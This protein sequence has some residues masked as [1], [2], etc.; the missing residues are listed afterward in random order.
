MISFACSDLA[1]FGLPLVTEESPEFARLL[2]ELQRMP[3][4]LP[5]ERLTGPAAVLINNTGLSVIGLIEIW[6]WTYTDGR[7]VGT[8]T[9]TPLASSAGIDL[10]TG[11]GFIPD[12]PDP[13]IILSGSK[14]LITPYGTY[15]DNSDVM[16]SRPPT[17]EEPCFC[18]PVGGLPEDLSEIAHVQLELDSVFLDDGLCLG[19]DRAGTFE[20]LTSG[21]ER[22]RQLVRTLKH[23]L[24]SGISRNALIEKLQPHACHVHDPEANGGRLVRS[25]A[26]WSIHRL[27]HATHGELIPWFDS[28]D[29]PPQ[30]SYHKV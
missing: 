5:P 28:F 20:S 23:D 7:G 19:P 11:R 24:A 13:R 22:R 16:T 26:R 17:K 27:S 4:K 10:L 12:W 6:K 30:F 25:F 2:S 21:L 18:W 3:V 29:I 1:R 9:L 14:R 15:G 8:A